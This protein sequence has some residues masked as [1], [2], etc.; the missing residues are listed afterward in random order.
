MPALTYR[1][2]SDPDSY[3]DYRDVIREK[4]PGQKNYVDL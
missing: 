3:R 2:G 4:N 1:P